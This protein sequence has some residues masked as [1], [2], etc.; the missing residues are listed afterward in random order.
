MATLA[1][2]NAA[3]ATATV[4]SADRGDRAGDGDSG[5]G[6]GAATAKLRRSAHARVYTQSDVNEFFVRNGGRD[7]AAAVA[8][9]AAA[10][11]AVAAVAAAVV[12]ADGLRMALKIF[13][14][15]FCCLFVAPRSFAAADGGDAERR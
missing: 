10:A 14:V 1:T 3:P 9:A 8:A 4:V 15:F 11:V 2:V 6:N 5:D 13:C 12:A 7:V